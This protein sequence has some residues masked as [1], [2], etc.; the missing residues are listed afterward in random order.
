MTI[1][2]HFL[3]NI[4]KITMI[5]NSRKSMS[6]IGGSESKICLRTLKFKSKKNAR[7]SFL[8]LEVITFIS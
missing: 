1:F 7:I 6:R 4:A 8:H 2:P 5:K 3:P